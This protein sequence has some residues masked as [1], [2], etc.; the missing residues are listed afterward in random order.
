MTFPSPSKAMTT[1]TPVIHLFR[2]LL[3]REI[4]L[5]GYFLPDEGMGMME[6]SDFSD[7]E[8]SADEDDVLEDAAG[9]DGEDMSDIEDIS[10]L[11]ESEEGLDEEEMLKLIQ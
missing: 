1:R 4:H 11:S 8:V 10:D 6:D 2:Y 3:I 9:S 5:T 7:E